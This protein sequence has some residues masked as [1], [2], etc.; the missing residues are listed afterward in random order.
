MRLCKALASAGILLIGPNSLWAQ[1]PPAAL[2]ACAKIAD[3]SGRL[4][5]FDREIARLSGA[6]PSDQQ[7]AVVSLA[8]EEKFGLSGQRLQ[9]LEAK[10]PAHRP[11][12]KELHAHIVRTSPGSYGHEVFELD[13]GQVWQQTETKSDFTIRT[14]DAVTIDSGALGSFWLSLS[15][16]QATRVKRLR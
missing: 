14:G 3:N 11:E 2:R 5:C 7:S 9:Q 13:N 15:A 6:D 16:H 10:E 1:S 12:I 8:P 4:A